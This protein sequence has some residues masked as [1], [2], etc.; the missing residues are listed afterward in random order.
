MKS[1][2][3]LVATAPICVCLMVITVL[4]IDLRSHLWPAAPALIN[5]ELC[6]KFN[7]TNL[8][9]RYV[10]P[11]LDSPVWRILRQGNH[12][13]SVD[14]NKNKESLNSKKTFKVKTVMRKDFI[15]NFRTFWWKVTIMAIM[16]TL[17]LRYY[18]FCKR[19]GL[20]YSPTNS[21]PMML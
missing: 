21:V 15:S 17:A 20:Q 1:V 19:S 9:R 12:F 2:A 5:W 10:T 16:V 3:V 11:P 8:L 14:V 13:Y 7:R 6:H 4:V 18:K